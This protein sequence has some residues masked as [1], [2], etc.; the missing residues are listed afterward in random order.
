MKRSVTAI[1][2][3]AVML[4]GVGAVPGSAAMPC[5][6]AAETAQEAAE[7]ETVTQNGV[8]YRLYLDSRPGYCADVIGYTDDIPADLVIPMVVE[9]PEAHYTVRKIG[10]EAFF[11]CA[12]LRSVMLPESVQEIG[13]AAFAVTTLQSITILNEQCTVYDAPSTFTS[14]F[15]GG[16]TDSAYGNYFDGVIRAYD[17]AEALRYARKYGYS[18]STMYEPTWKLDAAGTLTI[19]GS[20]PMRNYD[21]GKQP[22]F[23]MREHVRSVIS[24]SGVTSIGA[25]AFDG[26]PNLTSVS[27][28][29]GV[30]YIPN[31]AFCYCEKLSEISIPQSVTEIEDDAFEG[32]AWIKERRQEK[33]LLLVNGIL[34]DGQSCSGDVVIPDGVKHIPDR[35]FEDSAITSV[36][37]PDSV[38]SIG[39]WAFSGSARLRSVELP[40]SVTELGRCAFSH[41]S[42]LESV[43]LPAGLTEL[44]DGAFPG[45]DML[46]VFAFC[47]KL[48]NVQFSTGLKRIGQYAFSMTGLT[49][50]TIPETVTELGT[51][52]FFHCDS[53]KTLTILNPDCNFYKL[54]EGETDAPTSDNL[55]ICGYDNS[56]AETYA[57][58]HG[59]S[60]RSL[61][62]APEHEELGNVNG[63]AVINASDAA[64]VLIAAAALGAGN[65]AGLT[66]VQKQAADVN[67]DSSIN[68]SDAAIVLIYSAA[69][70][71]GKT[72]AKI[73]DYVK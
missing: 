6:Y 2:L 17:G 3:A 4:L 13:E 7:Y 45:E 73:T 38:T 33:Q 37:I 43:K 12:R 10:K 36:S 15:Y 65:D 63:D 62:A 32:T 59:F 67:K 56:T 31:T 51:Y 55:V 35:A 39:E 16:K 71:A 29:E 34:V 66:E 11:H 72:D 40:D 57:K 70:G 28:P 44:V 60:F 22:W 9:Q 46:S 49:E 27:I 18:Y 48:K 20:G 5:I 30:T 61:G 69:V 54:Y 64:V 8:I 23:E 50:I 68:A 53:L 14:G 26:Y 47:P 42:S 24:L 21:Y 1:T 41:C 52:A 19:S 25:F 58:Q